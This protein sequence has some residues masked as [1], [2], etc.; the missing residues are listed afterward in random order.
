MFPFY[1]AR[2]TSSAQSP[3]WHPASWTW[4]WMLCLALMLRAL[5]PEGYMPDPGARAQSMLTLSICTAHDPS[6]PGSA[7][8]PARGPAGHDC[9]LCLLAHHASGSPLTTF[10]ALGPL[11]AVAQALP[12]IAETF[13]AH[14]FRERGAPLGP[15]A[16][17]PHP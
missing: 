6:G 5:V 8:I 15:R 9:A 1:T 12:R 11:A 16:P 7:P 14:V 10:T 4:A 13:I 2:M 17:P 3:A